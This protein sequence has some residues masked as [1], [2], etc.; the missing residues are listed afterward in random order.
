MNTSMPDPKYEA[1]ILRQ[2]KHDV[3][4]YAFKSKDVAERALSMR[5]SLYALQLP[6]GKLVALVGSIESAYAALPSSAHRTKIFQPSIELWI[7]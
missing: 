5:H 2:S 4:V 1:Y 3:Q 7:C 6:G